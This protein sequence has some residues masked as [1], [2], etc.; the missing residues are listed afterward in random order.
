MPNRSMLVAASLSLLAVACAKESS[1][2]AEPSASATSA[3][4]SESPSESPSPSE[5][6]APVEV[7]TGA[8]FYSDDFK[9]TAKGWP[10]RSNENA[11][12][13]YH[14]DYATPLYTVK[15]NKAKVHLFPHP[16]FRGVTQ[17]QL[18]DYEVTALIQT[19]LNL[20]RKDWFGV[21]CRDLNNKRYSFEMGLD[22]T[23]DD[24]SPWVIAEHDG[25]KLEVLAK[26]EHKVGGSA[27][28]VSGAC[29][30]GADGG[31]ATLVMK[32]NDEVVGSVA[33]DSPLTAG[34]G[35]IYLYSDS[36]SA[37]VNVL[38]FAARSA[39]AA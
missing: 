20:G 15:A 37:T 32:I 21:T 22:T 9:T 16:E 23:G 25:G 11:T 38:S 13:T 5:S 1:P 18:A 27:F 34:Y 35:G 14:T 36:G 33:D 10:N 7:T 19:T 28:E 29:V 24:L 12:Y 26:G 31:P 2:R 3:T 39:E 17:Q 4:V 30:G 6:T 8:V